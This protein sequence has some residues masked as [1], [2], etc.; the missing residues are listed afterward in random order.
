M[1]SENKVIIIGHRGASKI[2][3]ENTLK[4]FREAIRLG[5]DSIE[6]DVQQTV[7]GELVI[8]HDS[9]I[10]RITGMEGYVE[11]MTLDELKKLDFGN[12]ETIPTLSELIELA[13]EKIALN[14]EI[15]VE[16]IT[17][18]VVELFQDYDIL[19]SVLI[20][21][22]LHDEL[23][24]IQKIN[25][26]IRLATLV[27]VGP[28]LFSEWEFKKS[29]IDYTYQNRFYAINPLFKLADKKFIE[30]AHKKKIKVF[31]WT[32]DS[33]IAMKKLIAKGVDGII[34][35]DISRLKEVL[36]LI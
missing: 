30:Y 11:E 18:K 6:F 22:F 1:D 27:P 17:K 13:K 4:A 29:L 33:G 20:S 19:E 25:S 32:V 28:G 2:A 21:S 8:I 7:D 36:N 3:P 26:T 10:Q 14:C 23:I 5:A 35:N 34:T 15:K 31:P 24:K 16:G 12:G 9:N